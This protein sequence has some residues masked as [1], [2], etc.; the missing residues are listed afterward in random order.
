MNKYKSIRD[1][2]EDLPKK[3]KITFSKEEIEQEFPNLKRHNIQLTLYRLVRKKKVQSVWR[4][5]WVVVPVEYGLKGIVDP[6]EYVAQL[7]NYLGQNYYIGLLSAAA[8][9]GAAHQQPMELMLITE[10]RHLKDKKKSDTK[11]NFTTKKEIPQQYLQQITARSGYIPVSTPELTAIDLLLYVKNVGGINRVATVL[12]ELAEVLDFDKISS[13]FFKN[14]SIADVQRLGYL[15]ETV[16]FSDIAEQ[17][18]RKAKEANLKFRKYP[19]CIKRK[20]KNLSD[21]EVNERWKIVV[22]EIIDID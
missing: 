20:Q 15:I 21:F 16:G 22:N 1:W 14:I 17:L 3:G 11:I 4:S 10:S 19:L 7:M 6:I 13:S 12:S 18:Y 2:I 8:I 5:F 9:H